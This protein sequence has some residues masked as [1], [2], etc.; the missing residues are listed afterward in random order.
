MSLYDTPPQGPGSGWGGNPA[1]GKL[2]VTGAATLAIIA[3]LLIGMVMVKVAPGWV[4]LGVAFL[5]LAV[6]LIR[7]EGFASLVFGAITMGMVAF[8]GG[9][10]GLPNTGNPFKA[11]RGHEVPSFTGVP[12][13]RKPLRVRSFLLLPPKARP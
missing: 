8:L 6:S 1:G 13:E 3:V 11:T 9:G 4:I 2:A 7:S 10:C 5:G 12:A